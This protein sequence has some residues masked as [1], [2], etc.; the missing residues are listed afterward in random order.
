MS[1]PQVLHP[2]FNHLRSQFVVFPAFAEPRADPAIKEAERLKGKKDRD[3]WR[4]T[5]ST[6]SIGVFE[7]PMR[8]CEVPWGFMGSHGSCFFLDAQSTWTRPLPPLPDSTRFSPETNVTGTGTSLFVGLKLGHFETEPLSENAAR[9]Q[10][11]LDCSLCILCI[12]RDQSP[13]KMLAD[14]SET[15]TICRAFC[16]LCEETSCI[17]FRSLRKRTNAA[18]NEVP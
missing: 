16:R 3:R 18:D 7:G 9:P 2:S 10:E 6:H 1:E 4:S 14:R 12:H 15:R 8:F 11:A 13:I 17:P 5:G